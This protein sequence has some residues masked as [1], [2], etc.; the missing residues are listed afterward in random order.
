MD[1][2]ITY[3]LAYLSRIHVSLCAACVE[4][5][6]HDCGSLGPVSHGRHRGGCD[7][8]RHVE[9]CSCCGGEIP[10][11]FMSDSTYDEDLARP[12]GMCPGTLRT[13]D[14]GHVLGCGAWTAAAYQALDAALEARKVT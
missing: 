14:A 9:I 8:A 7:G 1:Q 5:D 10:R 6:D 13:D 4:R 2:V 11:Q 3:Q 12:D